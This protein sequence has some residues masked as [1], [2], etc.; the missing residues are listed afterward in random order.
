MTALDQ[1]HLV[2]HQRNLSLSAANNG[3]FGFDHSY[4]GGSQCAPA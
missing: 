2:A 4:D 3:G 1:S